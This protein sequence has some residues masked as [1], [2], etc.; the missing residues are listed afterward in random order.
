MRK[1][2]FICL[3]LV[4]LSLSIAGC[5]RDTGYSIQKAIDKGDPIFK[6]LN[7]DGQVIRYSVDN[8]NDEYGGAGKGIKT[9]VCTEITK[10]DSGGGE[11]FYS[12]SGCTADN[13]EMSYFL[14]RK[15]K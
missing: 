10:E 12:I 11:I 6:D 15:K 2:P 5:K 3:L 4:L 8:S 14:I 7:Y 13:P 9:D 1:L